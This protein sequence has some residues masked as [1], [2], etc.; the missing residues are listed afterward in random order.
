[1][2]KRPALP[3]TLVKEFHNTFGHPILKSPELP[4]VARMKLRLNLL[5]EEVK[6]LIEAHSG[7]DLSH[8]YLRAAVLR[9]NHAME[10][11][12]SAPDYEFRAADLV[13]IADATTDIE[14]I[15]NGNALEYGIPLNETMA[16][17][18]RSNMTKTD[19]EGRPIYNEDGKVM[20]GPNYEAPDLKGVL[21]G[22]HPPC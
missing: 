13:A 11:V 16:E 17:V 4:P 1:M 18:H 7:D 21:F 14:Y 5:M 22:G 8:Q 10:L 9:V 6:E 20:K 3:I 15:N 19:E 2:S 12:K